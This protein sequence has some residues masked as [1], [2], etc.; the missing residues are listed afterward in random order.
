MAKFF[1][2]DVRRERGGMK[3]FTARAAKARYF[4]IHGSTTESKAT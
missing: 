3:Q 1:C 2:F 4:P